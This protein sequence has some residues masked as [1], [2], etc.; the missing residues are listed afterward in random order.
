MKGKLKIRALVNW[1]AS[2]LSVAML[3]SMAA[4]PA[5]AALAANSVDSAAIVD[6]QVKTRDIRKRAVTAK[7]IARGAVR[8]AQIQN[9]SIMNADI[10]ANAAIDDSK[11]NYATKTGYLSIPPAAFSPLNESYVYSIG[12]TGF[13]VTGGTPSG[14]FY[15]PIQLP[16]GAVLK[17]LTY[18]SQD[19]SGAS[20]TSATIARAK[21]SSPAS[22]PGLA[23][24]TTQGQPNS[25]AWQQRETSNITD[26][27][28]D[29]ATY[30]YSLRVFLGD[31]LA[32][33]IEAG[34][35]VIEYTYTTPGG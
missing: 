10:A 33:G 11:I 14:S 25:A 23:F 19:N 29:N 35:V 18:T 32:N 12:E 1:G 5:L 16:S 8:S 6:G 26:P 13:Y 9:G 17:K 31:N 28:I 21:N 30:S 24:V 15:A 22:L 27:T 34:P 7:K 4:A 20:F 2:L 3:L